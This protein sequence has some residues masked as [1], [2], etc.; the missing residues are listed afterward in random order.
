MIGFVYFVVKFGRVVGSVV[1]YQAFR[2]KIAKNE[3]GFNNNHFI[4][5]CG[6]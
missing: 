1:S 4:L 3:T 6:N 5:M 2:I